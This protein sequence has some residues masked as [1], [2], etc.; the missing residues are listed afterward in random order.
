MT[1][2]AIITIFNNDNFGNRLQ[3]YAVHELLRRRGI[4]ADTIPNTPPPRKSSPSASERKP[5]SSRAFPARIQL[6]L[7][8]AG[9]ALL[10]RRI[11]HHLQGRL[12]CFEAFNRKYLSISPEVIT[13]EHCSEDLARRYD[14]YFTGSDQIWNPHFRHG[15]EADFL[16]FAPCERRIAFAPSFG[17][18]TIPEEMKPLYARALSE[19]PH[20]SVR[21]EDGIGIIRDLTGR[22]ASLLPDPTL[23]LSC[24]DW[25]A[26]SA[27]PRDVQ[28]RPYLVLNFLGELTADARKKV[29]D[30]SR[31]FGLKI[32]HLQGVRDRL[33][34]QIGPSE[35][36]YLIDHAE[37][38]CTDSFHSAIFSTLLE[39]PLVLF[40]RIGGLHSMSSRTRTL[41]RML[42]IEDRLEDAIAGDDDLFR[43][44]AAIELKPLMETLRTRTEHYLDTVLQ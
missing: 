8:K 27:P 25:R 4:I 33:Y 30:I 17:T 36:L 13:A 29:R 42:G 6:Q 44:K 15:F 18:S 2:A 43:C 41:V 28:K 19:M 38:V 3:N 16:L 32:I 14:Y 34:A 37:L 26:I 21:E 39:T 11:A 9:R 7:K 10:R 40:D 23:C 1:K 35:Y 20:L 24:E 31:K 22:E 5:E 12:E